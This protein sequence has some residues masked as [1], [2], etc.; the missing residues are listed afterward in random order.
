[1]KN[2]NLRDYF[3]IIRTK[4]EILTIINGDKRL[5]HKYIILPKHIRRR[6]WVAE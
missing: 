4:K 3:P 5:R 6:Y 2:T 1:M